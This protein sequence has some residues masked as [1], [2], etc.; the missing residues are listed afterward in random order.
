VYFVE[1]SWFSSRNGRFVLNMKCV[2]LPDSNAKLISMAVGA[3]AWKIR[4][5][6]DMH[7]LAE[8]EPPIG[9]ARASAL[10]PCGRAPFPHPWT[11][12][13]RRVDDD[14]SA[15]RV[16]F[17]SRWG[18]DVDRREYHG[19]ACIEVQLTPCSQRTEASTSNFN[20]IIQ[21]ALWLGR[22]L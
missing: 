10:G 4:T 7:H 6:Y 21:K 12:G 22:Q 5:A 17:E 8:A 19:S 20:S 2:W 13:W 18:R 1:F 9:R 15:A 14:G 16:L 11:R 3:W